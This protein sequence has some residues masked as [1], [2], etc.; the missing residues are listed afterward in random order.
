M[1]ILFLFAQITFE[2]KREARN[3]EACPFDKAIEI[4]FRKI[5]NDDDK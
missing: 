4:R 3:A 2:T 5:N 1:L